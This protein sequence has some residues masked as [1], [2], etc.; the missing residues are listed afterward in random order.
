MKTSKSIL[1]PKL[2]ILI[3]I[4]FLSTVPGITTAEDQ[5]PPLTISKLKEKGSL[6]IGVDIPYGIMEFYNQSGQPSGIDIDIV[7]EI[8]EYLDV[9]VK[10]KSMAF[11]KLFDALKKGDVDIVASAVTITKERQASMLFSVP[12]LNAGMSM[13]VS[14]GNQDINTLNDL[15]GKNIGVL[16]GTVGEKL[17]T[18]SP[19]F[20]STVVTS[21]QTNDVRIKDL[22]EGKLDAIVVHFLVKD[23]DRFK[24]IG[25]PLSESYY[26]VVSRTNNN[27]LIEVVNKVLR[28][29]KRTGQLQKIK[30]KYLETK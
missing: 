6:V 27:E 21:Y 9:S 23:P 25:A 2:Y 17:I 20:K 1:K 12:Y 22:M 5:L 28:N 19:S 29:L 10:I 3:A 13:A 14:K 18:Q 11:S 7:H 4:L 30:K 15:K 24:L 16:K 26:G 8:A